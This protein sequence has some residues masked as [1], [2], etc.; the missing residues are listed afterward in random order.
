MDGDSFDALTWSVSARATRRQ[1]GMFA[2]A[3]ALGAAVLAGLGDAQPS[4]AKLRR[5]HAEHNVRGAKAI[6]CIN[7]VTERVPKRKRHKY[8]KAG[9]TRGACGAPTPTCTPV[10]APGSCGSD[11]CG[12][13]CACAAGAVCSGGTCTACTVS[14]P[15]GSTPVACGE[16]LKLAILPGG[17]VHVCPG[18]YRG[19]FTFGLTG[20]VY[21]SGNGDD[22]EVDT[23]LDAGNTDGSVVDI[24]G[25]GTFS[26]FSLRVTGGSSSGVSLGADGAVGNLTDCV[27]TGNASNSGGGIAVSRGV[28]HLSGCTIAKNTSSGDAGGILASSS[29]TSTITNTTITEN[30]AT[31][32]GGGILQT[33]GNLTLDASV[34]ITGNASNTLNPTSGGG[35]KVM[36]GTFNRG[37]AVITGNT[38]D[39]CSGAGC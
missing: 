28:V 23:I 39:D 1:L 25:D 38:P 20:S 12:G 6:M 5:A 3:G 31:F 34:T 11:G 21:G 2:T 19:S 26:L 35:V 9:A 32:T 16:A 10:C 15:P 8:L 22:P 17:D 37:G 13:M 30:T 14:C 29:G 4:A 27:I 24:I 18:R 7:G 33:S 36:A